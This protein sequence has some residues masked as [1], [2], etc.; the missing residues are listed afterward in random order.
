MEQTEAFFRCS[1]ALTVGL[2]FDI[3]GDMCILD[4]YARR[5]DG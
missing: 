4:M 1:C 3:G 5:R 2:M